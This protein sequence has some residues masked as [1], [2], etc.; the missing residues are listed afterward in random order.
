[1]A[2]P[3]LDRHGVDQQV[4]DLA[5]TIKKAQAPKIET[6]RSRLDQWGIESEGAGMGGL[7]S[8]MPSA[9]LA[10]LQD[11]SG[12]EASSLP[13]TQVIEHHEGAVGRAK[14]HRED[15]ENTDALDL[16]QKIIDDQPAIPRPQRRHTTY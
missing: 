4:S 16:A 13:I 10:A 8:R 12:S 6:M 7:D 1:M 3:L 11:A 5:E 15:G 2:D 9:D 14:Q